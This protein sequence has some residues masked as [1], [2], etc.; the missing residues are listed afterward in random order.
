MLWL[1]CHYV[2]PPDSSLLPLVHIR[3][4]LKMA[5]TCIKS[6]FIWRFHNILANNEWNAGSVN[7]IYKVTNHICTQ[8]V[9][10]VNGF[11]DAYSNRSRIFYMFYRNHL[12]AL[13]S[14]FIMFILEISC[15]LG[16]PDKAQGSSRAHILPIQTGV[17]LHFLPHSCF[18]SRTF[19]SPEDPQWVGAWWIG[20]LFTTIVAFLLALPILGFPKLLP[21]NVVLA[22]TW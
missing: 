6:T 9:L 19:L 4:S 15:A 13:F 3:T 20:F 5:K 1:V 18:L 11:Y 21:G 7:Y 10:L 22:C 12:V 17:L 8:D 2:L 16:M 14:G